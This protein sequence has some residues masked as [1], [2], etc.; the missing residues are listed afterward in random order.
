MNAFYEYLEEQTEDE[1]M[2]QDKRIESTNNFRLLSLYIDIR[3]Y[4]DEILKFKPFT[5]DILETM[6]YDRESS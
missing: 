1:S 4:E 2:D 5:V 3:F 6:T